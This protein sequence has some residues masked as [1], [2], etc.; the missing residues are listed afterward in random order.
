[1]RAECYR[2]LHRNGIS[3]RALEGPQKGR[4][5]GVETGRCIDMV[6]VEL[7]V[8][9]AGHRR[10]LAEGRKNVHAFVRGTLL[11]PG[12]HDTL[13]EA[14]AQQSIATATYNPWKGPQWMG[15]SPLFSETFAQAVHGAQSARVYMKDGSATVLLYGPRWSK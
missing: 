15:R 6:D 4:V 10:C 1:M 14:R 2:N 12:L 5:I 9:P 13:E 3:I 11:R 7:I 8:Q